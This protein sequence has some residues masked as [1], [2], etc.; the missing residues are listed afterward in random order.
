MAHL[1][2]NILT[3][4]ADHT[5]C[6]DSRSKAPQGEILST[7]A[8]SR[9]HD[10]SCEFVCRKKVLRNALVKAADL[11]R[12]ACRTRHHCSASSPLHLFQPG[13]CTSQQGILPGNILVQA[14]CNRRAV[15]RLAERKCVICWYEEIYLRRRQFRLYCRPR[16][17][18]YC[19]SLQL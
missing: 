3:G 19:S 15:V 7:N 12:K 10:V 16:H 9:Q 11:V 8:V 14:R 4:H 6:S 1:Q 2:A 18:G 5:T 17:E 13:F